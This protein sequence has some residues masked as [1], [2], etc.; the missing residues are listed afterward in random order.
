MFVSSVLE[1]LSL[2]QVLRASLHMEMAFSTSS[3]AA[4]CNTLQMKT[5]LLAE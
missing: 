3:A 5:T 2:T 1:S 4:A